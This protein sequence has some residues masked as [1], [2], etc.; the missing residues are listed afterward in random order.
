MPNHRKWY[1]FRRGKVHMRSPR[2]SEALIPQDRIAEDDLRSKTMRRVSRSDKNQERF[3]VKL[4]GALIAVVG[5]W[6]HHSPALNQFHRSSRSPF[7]ASSVSR[8]YR[9][10][11]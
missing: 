4:Y 1:H 6:T 8:L 5:L 10:I 9:S 11:P 3:W 2:R 7:A